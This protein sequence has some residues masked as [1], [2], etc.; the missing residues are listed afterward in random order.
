MDTK[1]IVWLP[2]AHFRLTSVAPL[3][4]LCCSAQGKMPARMRLLCQSLGQGLGQRGYSWA[5]GK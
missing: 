1:D 5:L 4:G 2:V 3:K